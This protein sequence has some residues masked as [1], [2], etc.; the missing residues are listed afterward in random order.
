[1]RKDVRYVVVC[2]GAKMPGEVVSL[3]MS[4]DRRRGEAG[5]SKRWACANEGQSRAREG[6][7]GKNATSD[8]VRAVGT[9]GRERQGS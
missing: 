6:D 8:G 7:G 4:Q 9:G 1:M 3:V 2:S 5:L